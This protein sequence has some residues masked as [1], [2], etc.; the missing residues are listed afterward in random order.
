MQRA[1][2]CARWATMPA[3]ALNFTPEALRPLA[4][5]VG[6]SQVLLGTDYLTRKE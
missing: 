6:P 2:D 4:A 5:N 1:T 3:D